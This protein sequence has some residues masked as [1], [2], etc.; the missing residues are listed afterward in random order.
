VNLGSFVQPKASFKAQIILKKCSF[1]ID[2]NIVAKSIVDLLSTLARIEGGDAFVDDVD[3]SSGSPSI[4]LSEGE[5]GDDRSDE[6][7]YSDHFAMLEKSLEKFVY[8]PD[9]NLYAQR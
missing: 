1:V 7:P 5:E 6:L 8:N 2:G 3:V 9:N 4:A